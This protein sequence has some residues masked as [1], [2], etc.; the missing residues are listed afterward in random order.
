MSEKKSSPLVNNARF[1]F[2]ERQLK[3][4]QRSH[5]DAV[6][7]GYIEKQDVLHI[8]RPRFAMDDEDKADLFLPGRSYWD[9]VPV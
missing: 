7:A 9:T 2:D 5:R 3:Y 1:K 4:I 6:K 8:E